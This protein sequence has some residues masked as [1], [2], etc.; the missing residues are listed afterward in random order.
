MSN[1][2]TCRNECNTVENRVPRKQRSRCYGVRDVGWLE[3]CRRLLALSFPLQ[4]SVSGEPAK[5]V[6]H[7]EP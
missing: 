1:I 6:Q 7:Q 3:A 4:L 5:K 2:K